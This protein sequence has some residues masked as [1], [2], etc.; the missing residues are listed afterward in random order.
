MFS[1]ELAKALLKYQINTNCT[2]TS[3][4]RKCGISHHKMGYL[5]G[6]YNT[7]VYKRCNSVKVDSKLEDGLRLMGIK[8]KIEIM[9]ECEEMKS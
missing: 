2:L 9:G 3:M 7:D 1:K 5:M 4:A 6:V 8:I